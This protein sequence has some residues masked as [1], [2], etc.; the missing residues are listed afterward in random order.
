MFIGI[1]KIL[2]NLAR[3]YIFF[4]KIVRNL[5]TF[6]ELYRNLIWPSLCE[7][8]SRFTKNSIRPSGFRVCVFRPCSSLFWS[9]FI[10]LFRFSCFPSYSSDFHSFFHFSSQEFGGSFQRGGR[11]GV[12]PSPGTGEWGL[13][14]GST[15]PEARGLGGLLANEY[16]GPIKKQTQ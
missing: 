3:L 9:F 13:R 1:C 2:S 16:Q 10:F 5:L 6:C 7:N 15:R 4:A 11:G 8:L 12:N 14:S